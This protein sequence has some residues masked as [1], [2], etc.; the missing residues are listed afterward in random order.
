MTEKLDDSPYRIV[1]GVTI[2]LVGY[3]KNL[4]NLLI[5]TNEWLC[6]AKSAALKLGEN[7]GDPVVSWHLV[8]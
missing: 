3:N 4:T 5:G 7:K 6:K 8:G 2:H 1:S